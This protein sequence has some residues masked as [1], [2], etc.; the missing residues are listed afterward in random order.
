[1]SEGEKKMLLIYGALNI[2]EGEN[3]VLLDEPDAHIHEGIKKDIYDL[4]KRYP[5]IYVTKPDKTV[6]TWRQYYKKIKFFTP[7]NHI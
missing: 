1:M 7:N 5:T 3:L 4:I 6:N 2:I